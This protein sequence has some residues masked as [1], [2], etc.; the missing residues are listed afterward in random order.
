MIQVTPHM[1]VLVAQE[2]LDF[3]KGIDGTA[4]VCRNALD[5]D[6]NCGHIFVFRNRSRTMIRLL[7]HDGHGIWLMNKRV[8]AGRFRYWLDADGDTT[9]WLDPHQL[10]VLLAGDDWRR[11]SPTAYWRKV[12]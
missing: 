10:Q 7:V 3:R 1:K 12:A 6:P 9:C 4:A 8:S 5:R 11:T 2:P